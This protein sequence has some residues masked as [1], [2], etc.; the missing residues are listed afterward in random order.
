MDQRKRSRFSL[1]NMFLLTAVCAV[2][3]AIARACL[4]D[5]HSSLAWLGAVAILCGPFASIGALYGGLYGM[6]R[7]VVM[8]LGLCAGMFGGLV[9]WEM[10]WYVRWP[11]VMVAGM[12]IFLS[13]GLVKWGGWPQKIEI[14]NEEAGD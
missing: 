5:A 12:V 11:G 1:A 9:A 3:A 2:I 6:S 13:V 10:P 14:R 7:G 8:G 4:G